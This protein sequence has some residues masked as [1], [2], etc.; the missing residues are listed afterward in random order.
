VRASQPN[1]DLGDQS[2][3]KA[4]YAV[5]FFGVPH[6]GL[7]IE[8]V[9][10]MVKE[11]SQQQRIPLLEEINRA[12]QL[13][14]SELES[15]INLAVDLKILSFYET[16]QTRKVIKVRIGVSLAFLD[17]SMTSL[18]CGWQLRTVR[19]LYQYRERRLCVA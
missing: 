6:R 4:T 2:L 17:W 11:E 3:V 10:S 14:T 8:D 18:G 12:S 13:I 7:F 9:I 16:G 15:F 1:G 19:R 5:L